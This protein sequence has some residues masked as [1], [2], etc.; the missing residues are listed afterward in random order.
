MT[1]DILHLHPTF[2][3]IAIGGT[4]GT[5]LFVG[6]GT[7]LAQG[8]PV[9]VW[10][11]YIIMGT[12][13][14]AVMV[15]LGELCTLFPVPGAITH[16]AT[17][18]VDPAMG[19]A[20]GYNYWYSWA[21]TTPVE[22]SAIAI[23]ISYWDPDQK[24]HPAV[25]IAIFFV[26]VCAINFLGVKWYGESE[27]IGSTIKVLAIIGL[28]ILGIVIDLGGGPNGDRIGFRYWIE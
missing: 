8:G 27:F 9:G 3:Q 25:W 4:I 17:R 19:F 26:L 23:V 10:L 11:S 12:G 20:L 5:G 22:L 16:M 7:A 21:I 6:S 1:A 13:V 15:A 18:F 28:I 24:I 2:V 14:Y